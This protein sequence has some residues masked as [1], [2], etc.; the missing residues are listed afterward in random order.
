MLG[1]SDREIAKDGLQIP[2]YY[3]GH[4]RMAT[5]PQLLDKDV[6]LVV[7]LPTFG[8]DEPDPAAYRLSE[9]AALYS[10]ADLKEMSDDATI[11]EAPLVP[12]R[13]WF[14][15]Y[16]TPNDK[17]DA[18]IEDGTWRQLPIE[19]TCDDGDLNVITRILAE[20]TCEGITE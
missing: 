12:G 6:N 1:L 3:P 10:T 11:V 18:L 17:V 8:D 14:M 7:G 9:L 4:V 2:L 19:R 15:I 5:V 16:L 13:V 20:R